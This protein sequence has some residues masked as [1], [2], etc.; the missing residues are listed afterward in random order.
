MKITEERPMSEAPKD[1]TRILGFWRNGECIVVWWNAD[2]DG[3]WS[4]AGDY[5]DVVGWTPCPVVRRKSV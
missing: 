4:D 3:W 2:A 1:G 5:A